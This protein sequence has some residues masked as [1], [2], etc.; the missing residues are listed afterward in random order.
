MKC[1]ILLFVAA[2]V[3]GLLAAPASDY[4]PTR[5][6]GPLI[7]YPD[8][9]PREVANENM[10]NDFSIE[11][12]L[13]DKPV[14]I[15]RTTTG[16]LFPQ[17]VFTF[18][19]E[20]GNAHEVEIEEGLE[21]VTHEDVEG[22]VVYLGT[23]GPDVLDLR[24]DERNLIA[25]MLGEDDTVDYKG[26]SGSSIVFL[27]AG[28]DK[29][30]GGYNT[31]IV[32][33]EADDDTIK[34]WDGDDK[35]YGGDGDDHII[36][37]RNDDLLVAGDGSGTDLLI[38]DAQFAAPGPGADTIWGCPQGGAKIYGDQ[39]SNANE[40]IGGD[41]IIYCYGK[42]SGLEYIFC[43]AGDDTIHVVR[44][45]SHTI[46]LGQAGS[47]TFHIWGDGE[48]WGHESLNIPDGAEQDKFYVYDGRPS[49]DNNGILVRG[50][51]GNDRV[52]YG[53]IAD[54]E[55]HGDEGLDLLD[56]GEDNDKIYGGPDQD[57]IYGNAGADA[58]INGEGGSDYIWG[59][60]GPDVISGGD[61]DDYIWGG[62]GEYDLFWDN[63][64]IS[65]D[66]G[67]DHIYGEAGTDILY[68]SGNGG[69]ADDNA[70]DFINGGIDGDYIF[71]GGGDDFLAGWAGADTIYGGDGAD[72]IW[73]DDGNDQIFGEDGADKIAGGSGDDQIDGAEGDDKIL[74][75]EGDDLIFGEDG[76]DQIDGGKGA[77]DLFGGAGD[78]ILIDRSGDKV[79]V[80]SGDSGSDIF[81]C[82]DNQQN[83]ADKV[84]GGAGIDEFWMDDIDQLGSDMDILLESN[85][86]VPSGLSVIG[87]GAGKPFVR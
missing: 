71:G 75:E 15:V 69:L 46:A 9:D 45:G 38:G 6:A 77:D 31:D 53:G 39:V 3:G 19:D 65:G 32:Y 36:G 26:S 82:L 1:L 70:S 25:F 35:L 37:G 67:S 66:N 48:F 80:L 20:D 51:K 49:S 23:S 40:A 58:E 17:W 76:D 62:N 33:G 50:G 47:D 43:G 42:M 27:G 16:R 86:G 2:C 79:D 87:P 14:S 54:D 24:N 60:D 10:P 8:D 83:N 81:D 30:D 22:W 11:L 59:G 84:T 28:E 52:Y 72:S 29:F 7:V 21:A 68:G 57:Y 41:D 78:D 12:E 64:T 44:V 13:N 73:G 18:Y 56:G 4:F 5:A 74:G 63:D 61:G 34:G 85:A 55:I